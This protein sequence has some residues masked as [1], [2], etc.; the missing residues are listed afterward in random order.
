MPP[1]PTRFI[2]TTLGLAVAVATTLL[3]GVPAHAADYD[4]VIRNGRVMNP[5]NG[6]DSV[7]DVGIRDGRIAALSRDPLSGAAEMDAAGL[8]VAPGFIDLHAHGQAEFEA[9][10]QAQDGVTTQLEMEAGVYPVADWYASR[11]GKAPINYGAT[12][13]HL[14]VRIVTMVDLA[15]LGL[16]EKD[17]AVGL[18]NNPHFE[19]ISRQRSWMEDAASAEQIA[20]MQERLQRGLDEGALGIGYGI[21]YTAGATRE[22]IYRM[23]AL[24]RANG[25]TNFV[26]A[27]FGA[28]TELGGGVDAVQELLANAAA[29]GAGLHIVHIG[30]T[31]LSRVPLLLEMIDSAQQQGLDVTTEVYPYTAWSTFIGAA[32]FNGDFTRNLGLDYGDIELPETGE[33]LDQA[34]FERLRAEAPQT[35]IVGHGMTEDNVTAAVA[36]PGVMIASDGMFYQD[37]RAHPRGAGTFSRVLGYYVRE[38]GALGLMEALGK[39]SYLPAKRLESAVPQMQRKGRIEVGADAD[40]VLFD[41]DRV[42]DRATFAE[43][44]LPSTGIDHVLVNGVFVVRDGKPQRG[45]HPGQPVRREQ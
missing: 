27:R 38:R 22:E 41:P 18:L 26:H 5:A 20:A 23:F 17:L 6:L 9:W 16:T 2:L 30:S 7:R 44:A 11:I 32:I 45:S 4:L 31:G 24:A 34:R 40:L 36:H 29:T 14:R 42:A 3:A 1:V 15:A 37:G 28:D 12:V 33:R 13:G 39:M 43:P 35:I 10:L 8:V 19:T 25:V 21:N